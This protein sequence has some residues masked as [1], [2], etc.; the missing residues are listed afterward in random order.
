MAAVTFPIVIPGLHA[1]PTVKDLLRSSQTYNLLP[2]DG[3]QPEVPKI[4]LQEL[5]RIFAR[6]KVQNIF[7]LHLIHGHFQIEE[8]KIMLGTPLTS[9]RGCWT[10]PTPIRDINPAEIHGHIF[11]LTVSGEMQAYEYRQGPTLCLDDVDPMFFQEL[12]KYLQTH[13][14]V[15]LLGLQVL[16]N[17]A[18]A[19]MSEFILANKGTVM[20]DERDVKSRGEAFCIT[21]FIL[22]EQF[23][24]S[25]KHAPTIRETHQVFFDGDIKT[26]NQLMAI[27]RGEEIVF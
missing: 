16:G 7:G 12:I 24:D 1:P 10:Q 27:L 20:L 4:H 5:A 17:D 3:D 15:D 21:G 22:K 14:L 18:P 6:F 9:V 8:G 11:K 13:H 2:D 26:E 19:T 25:E 23:K